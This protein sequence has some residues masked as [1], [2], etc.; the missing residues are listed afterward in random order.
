M[1]DYRDRFD[2]TADAGL[3]ALIA[4]LNKAKGV[5]ATYNEQHGVVMIDTEGDE[6]YAK[7]GEKP[8]TFSIY[9]MSGPVKE[10]FTRNATIEYAVTSMK[11]WAAQIRKWKKNPQAYRAGGDYRPM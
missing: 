9:A 3:A 7:H 6:W 4:A 8:G 11:Q 2:E 5:H 1:R 10:P